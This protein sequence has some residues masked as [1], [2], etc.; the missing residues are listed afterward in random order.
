M[1]A[2]LKELSHQLLGTV[3]DNPDVLE[4][5]ATDSS[6]FQ[7][8]P[9]GVVYPN[10][11]ADVRK[12]VAFIAEKAAAG[13]PVSIIPR[14]KGGD[15]GGGA[16]GEGVQLVLPS[17]MNKLLRLERDYVVVQPGMSLRTLQQ[18][19][20]THGRYLPPVP[21]SLDST[22][23]G[24][25]VSN[26]DAG[27]KAY[28][29]GSFR[30]FVKSLKVVVSDGTVI[31]TRRISA[32]ELNRKK[33]LD[34]M[35]G[36][37]YRKLDNILLDHSELIHKRQPRSSRNTA[38]YAL[39]KV[40]GRDGSFD[41]G[42]I[43]IGA[44]GTELVDQSLLA[45]LQEHRPGDIEGIVPDKLPKAML[46][47]EF[48]DSAQL[49]QKIRSTRG[50]R[51]MRRLG[52]TTRIST[53]PIEQVAIWKIRRDA[54][55][56]MALSGQGRKALPFIDDAAVPVVRLAEF[57]DKTHK[58]LAKHDLEAAIWGHA[59]NGH[60]H[61]LPF[62]DL[63]KRRDVD[64]LFHLNHEFHEMVI[65]M[66]GTI[67]AAHN[68]GLLRATYMTKLYGEE[69]GELMAATKHAFDPL[70]IFNPMH[71]TQATEA[72]ARQHLRDSYNLRH[73]YEHI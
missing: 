14:G 44:Q 39:S 3:T 30:S 24:G 63:A 22:T 57:I 61:L 28:K 51:V 40:R 16:I 34:T 62:L 70:S 65:A 11:T 35:E 47:T 37:L 32:R 25:A 59:G 66:G 7:V 17:H 20:Y 5:F 23:V 73:L 67:S 72:Y 8:T 41:L 55:S 71:K 42:Q 9:A 45:F 60:L 33:G 15:A 26:D 18:V 53:D 12:T 50:E 58:L 10:N 52:A 49:T 21:T 13:R 43:F 4:H 56:L 29:Y 6:I 27:A 46:I 36:E 64:R 1:K 38:G 19:L 69:L 54:P 2:Y 48:D 68:D 31:Q